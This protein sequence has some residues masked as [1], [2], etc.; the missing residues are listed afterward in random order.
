MFP[1]QRRTT[2]WWFLIPLLTFGLGT[3]VM[4]LVG[5]ARLRSRIHMIAG[6]GY[7]LLTV[8]SFVAMQFTDPVRIGPLDALIFAMWMI[9]WVGGT[10]HVA[11]LQGRVPGSAPSPPISG[12]PI[13]DP[14]LLAAKARMQRRWEARAIL[15]NDRVLA[16]EL[17]IGRP[18][19][20]RQWEDGGLVDINHVPA[21]T[22]T[23]E[24]EL[25]PP[26]A[27]TVVAVRDRLGGFSGPEELIVYC[28]AV[29]PDRLAL[30]RDRLV[31]VPL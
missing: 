21:A 15:R 14:A 8:M 5:A 30:I 20:P 27:A 13:A 2:W 24:L 11:V 12:P 31:F 10:G 4:V 18:D 26:V 22:L 17:R 25:P 29:T 1:T 23:T 16:A 6:V 7:L 28:D 19:L 9:T 3:S